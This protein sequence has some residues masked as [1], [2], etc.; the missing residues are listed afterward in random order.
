LAAELGGMTGSAAAAEYEERTISVKIL[1]APQRKIESGISWHSWDRRT[2]WNGEPNEFTRDFT[3]VG[4][5]SAAVQKAFEPSRVR[6][7]SDHCHID[8]SPE[9]ASS[10]ASSS[11]LKSEAL[12]GS[13]RVRQWLHA[14]WNIFRALWLGRQT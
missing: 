5:A 13:S 8:I 2:W 1:V 7:S 11:E 12:P 6:S 3:L 4:I 14:Q 10:Q 9:A